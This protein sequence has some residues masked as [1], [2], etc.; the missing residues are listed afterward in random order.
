MVK[1]LIKQIRHLTA[2]FLL[3]LLTE[4]AWSA[5]F[6]ATV[7]QTV[8]A[9]YETLELT[10]RTDQDSGKSPDL[11]PLHRDFEVVSTRQNRQIRIINGQTESWQ[12]WIVT[13]APKREGKLIIPALKLGSLRSE[14]IAIQVEKSVSS[15]NQAANPIFMRTEVDNEFVYIQQQVVLTLKVYYRVNLYDDSRLSPL[16]I[17][18]AIVQ[19][20]GETRKYD[21]II[22]GK[23]YGVFE[24]KFAIHPQ[25]TG[26]ME[27]PAMTF[28]GTMAERN[29]P[30]GGMFSMS[31]GRPVVAR[32]P[33]IQ[34][35]VQPQPVSYQGRNWLPANN[36]SLTESWSQNLDQVHVGDA[37][38]RTVAITADGLT[39]AQ[40]P[41]IQPP[42]L[43]NANVYP[44]QSKTEDTPTETGI[45]GQKLD[46]LAIIPTQPGPLTLPAVRYRWYDTLNNQEKV[47]ELQARTIKVLPASNSSLPALPVQQE[48][49][50]PVAIKTPSLECPPPPEPIL[51]PGT[52]SSISLWQV[53]TGLFAL[54]WLSTLGLWF[55]ARQNQIPVVTDAITSTEPA[56]DES[57]AFKMVTQACQQENA[58]EVRLALIEWC[59]SRYRDS[60]LSHLERCMDKLGSKTLRQQLQQMEAALYSNRKE[61]VPFKE[62][63]Q[64][65]QALR[66]AGQKQRANQSLPELYPKNK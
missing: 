44:D 23:Q 10:L 31:S 25:K 52:E 55:K 38:T 2:F 63:L 64:T 43:A 21:E 59:Q 9:Q 11:G 3:L 46:A 42:K 58:N 48:T 56:Y 12:D 60:S 7:D 1:L 26:L 51:L 35:N 32:S 53:L 62:I 28:N 66:K 57:S 22:D 65:C 18:G 4:T 41:G 17:D 5:N 13:L 8:I 16:N 24:L 37:I 50:E 33:E 15:S 49:P 6:Q 14:P 39:S 40:L 47:A 54:L 27:I 19:Q 36:L 20:L 45:I 34:L 29:D 61:T 30:F